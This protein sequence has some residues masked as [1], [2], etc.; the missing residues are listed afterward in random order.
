MARKRKA[1]HVFMPNGGEDGVILVWRGKPDTMER[2]VEC[3]GKPFSQWG[4]NEDTA[5]SRVHDVMEGWHTT[6]LHQ[7]QVLTLHEQHPD[8]EF[9]DSFMKE[10]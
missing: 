1:V 9:V 2:W 4:V 10:D 7:D 6:V 3:R 5:M 8:F